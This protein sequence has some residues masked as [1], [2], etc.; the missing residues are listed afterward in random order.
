MQ[1]A[2]QPN[3]SSHR[4]VCSWFVTE[5]FTTQENQD[6][7][8]HRNDQ[9]KSPP[10][11][12]T[13]IQAQTTCIYCIA[14]EY[15]CNA[16]TDGNPRFIFACTWECGSGHVLSAKQSRVLRARHASWIAESR[17]RSNTLKLLVSVALSFCMGSGPSGIHVIAQGNKNQMLN[18][19]KKGPNCM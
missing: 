15:I 8:V 19:N 16:H 17:G 5:S 7:E 6:V 1:E 14:L 18:K 10:D 9:G 2:N 13:Y 3:P 12:L 4:G 11:T